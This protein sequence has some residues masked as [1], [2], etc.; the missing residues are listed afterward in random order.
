MVMPIGDDNTGRR[1][2]PVVNYVLL[3]LNVLVFIFCQGLGA[4]EKFTMGFS[5]VPKEITTGKD[6]VTE[7]RQI[8]VP[9]TGQ[10]ITVPGLEPT[11]ISP[12]ITLITSMFMH[13]GI[14]HLFGNM[15]FLW[16]FGDNIEEAAGHARYLAFYLL[17]GVLAG[18][19]QIGIDTDGTL[20]SLGASGAISGVLGGYMVLFPRNRVRVLMLRSIV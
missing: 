19:A 1:T 16:I 4:N 7:P 9:P 18:L 12:Y 5:T 11:P 17:C 10:E 6:I 13:G 3:A 15:L 8:E 20:P 14:A 2:T